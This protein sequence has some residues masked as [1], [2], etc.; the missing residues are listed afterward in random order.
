[1]ANTFYFGTGEFSVNDQNID[2]LIRN[3]NEYISKGLWK[4]QLQDC[5]GIKE[6]GEHTKRYDCCYEALKSCVDSNCHTLAELMSHVSVRPV[7]QIVRSRKEYSL[8]E[9]GTIV[10]AVDP[11]GINIA[12]AK[13]ERTVG[14][15]I[16]MDEV[17]QVLVTL[18]LTDEQIE[19]ML[20]V[21]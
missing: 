4:W 5:L 15:I 10:G 20:N 12:W 1:M 17:K 6:N 7:A 14:E 21:M 8:R 3:L 2:R 11:N 9:D 13:S 16:K 19:R 18:S